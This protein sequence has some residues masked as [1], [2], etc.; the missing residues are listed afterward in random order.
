MP[1]LIKKKNKIYL[2]KELPRRAAIIFLGL[3]PLLPIAGCGRKSYPV[4]PKDSKRHR[5]YPK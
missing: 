4:R 3:L 1:Y 5:D 2:E